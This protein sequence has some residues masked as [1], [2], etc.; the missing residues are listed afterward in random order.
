M[1]FWSE[2]DRVIDLVSKLPTIQP[3]MLVFHSECT[4]PT[5]GSYNTIPFYSSEMTKA[6]GV[7]SSKS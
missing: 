4:K 2:T 1:G 5:D 6:T 3:T 7:I